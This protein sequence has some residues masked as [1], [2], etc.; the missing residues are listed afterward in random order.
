MVPCS[1]AVECF[2]LDNSSIFS[3]IFNLFIPVELIFQVWESSL[4]LSGLYSKILE[5]NV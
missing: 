4:Q 5:V 2:V 1:A 3:L